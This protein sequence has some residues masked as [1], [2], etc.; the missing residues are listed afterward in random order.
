MKCKKEGKKVK[1]FEQ[2]LKEEIKGLNSWQEGLEEGM[3]LGAMI[4]A[5][6]LLTDKN[7]S[8]DEKVKSIHAVMGFKYE[9]EKMLK[10]ARETREAHK[11]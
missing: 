9:R 1:V 7:M 5:K 2:D 10:E 8:D 6:R 11:K 3:I 4:I